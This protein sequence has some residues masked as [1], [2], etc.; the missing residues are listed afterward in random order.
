MLRTRRYQPRR[1]SGMKF[2]AGSVLSP[3]FANFFC[4]SERGQKWA[5]SCTNCCSWTGRTCARCHE[6]ADAYPHSPSTAIPSCQT[7]LEYYGCPECH[8]L[9]AAGRRQQEVSDEL[10]DDL[11]LREAPRA[12]MTGRLRDGKRLVMRIGSFLG[13]R[14]LCPLCLT[15]CTT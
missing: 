10:H 14:S 4:L 13:Q 11:L 2:Q 5:R 15:G 3:K 12:E 8:I 9:E 7:P 6:L 1:A